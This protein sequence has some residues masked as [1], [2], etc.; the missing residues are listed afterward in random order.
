MQGQLTNNI[1]PMKEIHWGSISSTE[2]VGIEWLPIDG[3]LNGAAAS[4]SDTLE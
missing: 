4:V 1:L 3:R 2:G